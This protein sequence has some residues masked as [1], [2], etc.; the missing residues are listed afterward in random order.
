MPLT[1]RF[2]AMFTVAAAAG[3]VAASCG[4]SGAN[5]TSGASGGSSNGPTSIVQLGD[6]IAAGEGTLYGF[7]FDTS[8]G[9]W[10]G[11]SNPDPPWS[12]QYP[13]CHQ[14]K[15]AYGQVLADSYPKAKFT[16]LACTG[17]TFA[18]GVEGPW[19]TAVPAQF[20]NWDTKTGL[21]ATYGAARPDLVLVS[22]GANDVHFSAI[23]VQCVSSF[24]LDPGAGQCTRSSPNGPNDVIT[25]DFTDRLPALKANLI[26]LAQWIRAR[27]ISLEGQQ[28]G[29]KTRIVFTTYPDVFPANV[30]PGG[31]DLCPDTSLLSN[32]QVRY[33]SSL[34]RQLDGDIVSWVTDYAKAHDDKYLRA[35][36]LEN[37]YQ[38]KTWCAKSQKTG[39]WVTP[40]AY[41]LSIYQGLANL[42]NRNPA[43]T[44]P[45]P[46][47]Q[48]AIAAALK[49]VVAKLFSQS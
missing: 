19:S 24:V 5:S 45:T 16:Q 25:K 35:V 38:G 11:P 47:G 41:G 37:A 30:P 3:L 10:Q 39:A 28:A 32:D 8:S 17:S 34:L 31:K 42:A 4:A 40:D 18:Q 20:G 49:P 43:P 21:N 23:M 44:H 14:S 15:Y 7:T 2:A 13:E 33:F 36:N 1:R 46:S 48:R 12:G 9:R 26:T 29:S 6:S 27:A 22:L